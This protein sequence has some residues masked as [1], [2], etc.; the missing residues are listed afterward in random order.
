M[1][2]PG[3]VGTIVGDRH[4]TGHDRIGVKTQPQVSNQRQCEDTCQEEHRRQ[5]QQQKRG[6]QGVAPAAMSTCSVVSW[7]W[8]M[9]AGGGV[10]PVRVLLRF[11]CNTSLIWAY[12]GVC[13]LGRA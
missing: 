2:K 7:A 12:N 8:F 5:K 6:H 11:R 4:Q 10:T 3:P 13:G 9:A 1:E